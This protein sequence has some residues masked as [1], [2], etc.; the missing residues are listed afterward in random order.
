MGIAEITLTAF[1]TV[2]ACALA[3]GLLLRDL[4]A[5]GRAAPASSSTGLRL[6]RTPDAFDQRPAHDLASRLD[7]GFDRL[8]LESG[9]DQQSQTVFQ[10]MIAAAL[11]FGGGLWLYHDQPLLG[12]AGAMAGLGVPLLWLSVW[13]GR[14][15][16]AVR[17]QLPHVIEMLARATRAGRS[18]DQA[19]ALV[20]QEAGGLL[21]QEFQRCQ[22]QL[23]MG[24]GFDKVIKSLAG[25]V[26]LMEIQILATTLIVQRQ[27]GGPLSDT[28]DRMSAVIRDRLTAHRQI[29]AATAAGRMSTVV[30]AS[31]APLA[32][33]FLFSFQR[34]HLNV[35]FA[36]QI[37]R[38][39]LWLAMILETIGLT[40][41]ALLLRMER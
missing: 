37:G 13:R 34:D 22:Q 5:T 26:R 31:I 32:V 16:R 15:M 39:M 11:L 12:V 28:L 33:I 8:V 27:S 10:L 18:I 20:A 29:R 21:G 2:A 24:R 19:M 6:R 30:V 3:V 36:D 9:T 35:L 17:E 23:A 40:W 25:R 41:V 7:H 1:V 14:R 4:V 38:S